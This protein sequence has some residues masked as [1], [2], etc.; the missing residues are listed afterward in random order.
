MTTLQPGEEEIAPVD[1]RSFQR[2][3]RNMLLFSIPLWV[4]IVAIGMAIWNW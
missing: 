3:I 1:H 2:S 4:I